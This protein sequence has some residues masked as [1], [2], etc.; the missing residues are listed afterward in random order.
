[1][2]SVSVSVFQLRILVVAIVVAT[3]GQ[4][5]VTSIG[6]GRAASFAFVAQPSTGATAP[7]KRRSER[8]LTR[9]QESSRA[10]RHTHHPAGHPSPPPY[11]PLSAVRAKARAAVAPSV[12]TAENKEMELLIPRSVKTVKAP[13]AVEASPVE[14]EA[15]AAAGTKLILASIETLANSYDETRLSPMWPDSLRSQR[16]F[17]TTE[18]MMLFGACGGVATGIYGLIAF[19]RQRRR[20]RFR[21]LQSSLGAIPASSQASQYADRG[22]SPR[23]FPHQFEAAIRGL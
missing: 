9:P 12:A 23:L 2:M 3:V 19:G 17:A 8:P 4:L 6:D 22:A 1:M 13:A 7:E 11:G 18:L 14:A 5:V 20:Q 21:G 15:Q 16:P 10:I